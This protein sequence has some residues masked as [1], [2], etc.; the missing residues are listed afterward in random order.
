MRAPKGRG[1]RLAAAVAAVSALAL[2][3]SACGTD[4][5]G[6]EGGEGSGK[7]TVTFWDNNGGVRTEV[8]K[9]IISRFEKKNPDIKVKYVGVAAADVQS[10]YDTAIAGGK[11]LPDVG[12]VGTA[13]LASL[14]AQDALDPVTDRIEDSSLKGGFDPNLVKSVQ[15]AGGGDELFSVP[16]SANMGVLWYRTDLFEAAGVPAPTTWDAFFTATEKLTDRKNNEFGF[17]FRG[18][19]GSIAQALDMM[20]GQSGIDS[21]W[22]GDSTTVNDP[23]NVAALEKYVALYKKTTPEADLN[24]D[25]TKM[26]AEFD[27]GR[28]GILQHNLGSFQNHLDALGKDKFAGVAM[29]VDAAGVRTTVSN[30]VDGIGLFKSSGNK[31]AAWK[32]IEF[33]ASAEANSLWNESAGAIPSNTQAQDD[34]WIASAGA[35]KIAIDALTDPK[36][37][38]VQLPYYLPDWNTLSKADSEPEFQKVVLGRLSAKDFLDAF[39][40]KLN[41]A[42]ADWKKHNS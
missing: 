4:G 20:Y 10:K 6:S 18:G 9:E 2:T 28:I 1:A 24:N 25:F 33:A 26:V 37:R 23:K 5:K 19:A 17:T 13:M 29:P 38:I 15:V 8:W 32:F 30:P 12:G 39:A 42:Q 34:D 41:A 16:T 27:N 3:A 36:T 22:N 14:V 35:T 21:F 31:Q 40:G 11:G 7:G